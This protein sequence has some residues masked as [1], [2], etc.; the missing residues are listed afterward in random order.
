[1]PAWQQANPLL[2][3]D[4]AEVFS[5]ANLR[6]LVNKPYQGENSAELRTAM[7]TIYNNRDNPNSPAVQQALRDIADIRGVPVEKIQADF[8]KYQ[9][10]LAQQRANGPEAEGL[11]ARNA[12]FMG[13]TGQLRYGDV[14]GQAFGVDPVFGALLNPTGGLVGPGNTALDLGNTAV[15]YHGAVHDAGGYMLNSHGVG[16]GYNYLN[17]EAR[18]PSNPLTGQQSGIQYWRGV[19]GNDAESQASQV[20]VA[21]G[22]TGETVWNTATRT[23][24]NVGNAGSNAYR[25]IREGDFGGLYNDGVRD[26]GTIGDTIRE[27]YRQTR[28]DV[29]Q[30]VESA[31]DVIREGWNDGYR[32][33]REGVGR[34]WDKASS[35]IF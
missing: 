27:G 1:V 28:R 33:V 34:L 6:S 21:V 13:N 5:D 3:R 9:Q 32:D 10:L 18:D 7:E 12:S 15:A 11:N 8:D 24:D 4:P 17:R 30:A 19:V 14:V 31:G 22:V 25:N 16:P 2:A 35:L 23:Y 29:G 20:A 26:I